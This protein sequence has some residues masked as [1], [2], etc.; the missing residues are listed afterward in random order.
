MPY[1]SAEAGKL[2]R[3]L[4]KEKGLSQEVLSGCAGISRSHLAYIEKG[5]VAPTADTLWRVCDALGIRISRLFE[6]L[7]ERQKF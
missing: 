1:N 6:L 7:E 3:S 5:T 2:I 4:R